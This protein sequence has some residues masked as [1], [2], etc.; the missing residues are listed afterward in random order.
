MIASMKK[1]VTSMA[2]KPETKRAL[3]EL[4]RKEQR[5]LSQMIDL[6]VQ[7]ALRARNGK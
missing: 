7:E 1:Q 2:L 5:S 3:Q 6:L 4:A